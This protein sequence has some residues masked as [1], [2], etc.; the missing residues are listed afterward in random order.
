MK[1]I[2][3]FEMNKPLTDEEVRQVNSAL[4]KALGKEVSMW[5]MDGDFSYSYYS[6]SK[7]EE[8]K[9][10]FREFLKKLV[11]PP[12]VTYKKVSGL[13]RI[14]F[15]GTGIIEKPKP[16]VEPKIGNNEWGIT[17]KDLKNMK[18]VNFHEISGELD[19]KK[20]NFTSEE[21]KNKLDD[22][23]EISDEV[24]GSLTKIINSGVVKW[25]H[26][27][28]ESRYTGLY[29]SKDEKWPWRIDS[30]IDGDSFSIIMKVPIN[31]D[32]SY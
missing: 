10:E 9:R 6:R 17:N 19:G 23:G 27:R 11:M 2:P 15:S 4:S 13:N 3:L 20:H 31:F 28:S 7:L 30:T 12:G 5:R 24:L 18:S 29:K 16:P 21:V 32:T 22:P 26:T 25:R 1:L 14:K 8:R